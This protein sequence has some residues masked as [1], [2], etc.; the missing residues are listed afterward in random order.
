MAVPF[1]MSLTTDKNVAS[2][3]PAL[4]AEI[5]RLGFDTLYIS[6]D[7]GFRPV[8]PLLTLAAAATKT[9]KLG[10]GLINPRLAHPVYHASNLLLL[11]EL[12]NGRA[13][14]TI[15]VGP[16]NE[17]LNTHHQKRLRMMRETM[18]I[19]RQVIERD[20]K[21]YEGEYFSVGKVVQF[22]HGPVRD[23]PITIG[24]WG[25]QVCELAGK[26]AAGVQTGCV[27]DVGYFSHLRDQMYAGARS[28]G[29]DPAKL[30][31][32]NATFWCI[33]EDPREAIEWMRDHIVDYM[34]L[35][36]VVSERMG[37]EPDRIQA[38]IRAR[39]M[40]DREGGRRLVSD[41]IVHKLC[42]AGSPESVIP[43][44]EQLIDA[45][46]TSIVVGPPLG[47]KP[48][49]FDVLRMVAERIIPHFR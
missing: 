27:A 47:I 4:A 46:A 40:G 26:I 34:A 39:E 15:G 2:E 7:L 1:S 32:E 8:W 44:I 9:I 30:T 13:V 14:C 25:P 17:W 31:L 6:D 48:F 42:I 37:V 18:D 11:D 33:T 19:M 41:E 22:N 36:D 43:H 21:D 38:I 23:I 10:P 5:E 3:Y 16:P 29:R 35:C 12:S 45:G 49:S 20:W 24:S 28:V